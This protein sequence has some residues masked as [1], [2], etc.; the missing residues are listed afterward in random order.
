M[1]IRPV[2]WALCG[3]GATL[4]TSAWGSKPVVLLPQNQD[5]NVATTIAKANFSLSQGAANNISLMKRQPWTE[6]K[7]DPFAKAAPPVKQKTTAP[8]ASRVEIPPPQPPAFPY[9]FVGRLLAEEKDAVFLSRNNQIYSVAAGDTLDGIYRIERVGG[10]ELEITY[11]PDRRKLTL[12]FDALASK[13]ATKAGIVLSQADVPSGNI[14]PAPVLPSGMAGGAHSNNN[15]Q[16]AE[17]LN[18]TL[19]S[20]MPSQMG[21]PNTAG[22]IP[23]P[24]LPSEMAGEAPSESNGLMTDDLRQMLA[25]PPPPEG[26]VL[27][28]MGSTPPPQ[29]D[30]MQTMGVPSSGG[31]AMPDAQAA[32]AAH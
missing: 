21:A 22:T 16:A 17:N 30:A 24:V 1:D 28:M 11:L 6:A 27:K 2:Y 8:I 26:D 25:P 10:N 13:P 15:G 32:P 31:Q 4:L 12:S 29:G 19:A 3:A 20:P 14:F 9:V 18:Q 23:P 7:S 5:A